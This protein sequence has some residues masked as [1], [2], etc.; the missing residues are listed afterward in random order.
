MM[1]LGSDPPC[2]L[3]MPVC[4]LQPAWVSGQN[5]GKR[6]CHQCQGKSLPSPGKAPL[7][8]AAL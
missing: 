8:T 6:Q 1:V 3:H 2:S 5:W 4:C 7:G